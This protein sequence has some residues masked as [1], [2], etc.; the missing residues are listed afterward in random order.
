MRVHDRMRGARPCRAGSCAAGARRGGAMALTRQL[1]ELAAHA[2]RAGVGDD[3][4]EQAK[5][6]FVD[7]I[8][9]MLAG[10][11][12][13]AVAALRRALQPLAGGPCTEVAGFSGTGPGEAALVNGTASHA[14]DFDDVALRGHPSAVMVPAI[15]ATAQALDC[16]GRQ[17]LDAYV[18]G[19]EAWAELVD[20]EA[21]MHHMKGWHPTGIFGAVGAAAACAA[22]RG[23]DARACGHAIGLGATQSAGLMANFGSM[24][25][26]LQAG[27]AAQAGVWAAQW[28]AHGLAAGEDV[29]EHEQGF[30][31]AVSP[32]GRVERGPRAAP[33]DGTAPWRIAGR[34]LSVKKY[35]T[36]FYTH[37]ALDAVLALLQARPVQAAEVA[38]VDVAMSR[39]H[40]TVLRNHR[41]ATGLQAKFS[42]EFAM[43][44]ALV[45]GRVGLAE[46]A[47]EAVRAEAI[48]Q[49]LERVH[50]A[51]CA[52][53][54]PAWHGAAVADRVTLTLRD[55]RRLESEPVRQAAGHAERPLGRQEL[56]E[57]FADC[58]AHGGRGDI[59][60]ALFD[61]LWSMQSL[62][63][64]DLF[65]S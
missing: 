17:M 32:Q 60:P 49:M 39:E 13:P 64:A 50:V 6:G 55:G 23:L 30:L 28:A 42:I 5:A 57:K 44:C 62:R 21:D 25:K 40:A 20:R 38:R 45:H 8:A 59:A 36:C 26:P 58:L 43:A 34:G 12:E 22:L 4:R 2:G 19:Y 52:D 47:D 31:A 9:T 51:H 37:R 3:A 11:E 1:G 35:P 15:L 46:L 7:A 53:Y 24:A 33:V 10:R 27:R 14:L 48:Q 18:A 29:L 16:T 61:R 41:P 65:P 54:D 63:A 56:R